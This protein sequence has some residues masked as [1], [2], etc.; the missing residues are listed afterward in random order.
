MD[1]VA[2]RRLLVKGFPDWIRAEDKESLLRHFGAK[3][4]VVM[5]TKG[6]MVC[7]SKP[8]GCIVRYRP[9]YM[10]HTPVSTRVQPHVLYIYLP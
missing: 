7:R 4:V 10:Y 9:S 6:R 5:P 1:A 2:K 8:R 3:D